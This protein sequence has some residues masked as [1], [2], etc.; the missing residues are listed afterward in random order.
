MAR[1]SP[2]ALTSAVRKAKDF[3]RRNP[4]KVSGVIDK[5]ERL[6]RSKAGSRTA[7]TVGRGGDALRKSLGLGRGGLPPAR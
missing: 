5:V 3:A 4:D 7:D 2:A 6:A 1:F